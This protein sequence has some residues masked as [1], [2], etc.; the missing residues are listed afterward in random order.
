MTRENR[1]IATLFFSWVCVQTFT[2]IG[3]HFAAFFLRRTT[4]FNSSAKCWSCEIYLKITGSELFTELCP[5]AGCHQLCSP[6]EPIPQKHK[7]WTR[8]L[9][10]CCPPATLVFLSSFS[11]YTYVQMYIFVHIGVERDLYV[12]RKKA[13]FI[14]LPLICFG[15]I[16]SWGHRM[17]WTERTN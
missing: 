11:P 6:T 14:I 10:L 8:W 4:T 9:L 7:K 15:G 16:A 5:C 13:R 12:W 2:G 17:Y 3:L 1:Y